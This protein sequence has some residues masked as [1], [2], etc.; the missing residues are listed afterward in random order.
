MNSGVVRSVQCRVGGD[1]GRLSI[2]DLWTPR[3]S[4]AA[5]CVAC[6]TT[7]ASVGAERHVVE[8]VG[9]HVT[10]DCSRRAVRHQTF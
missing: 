4:G 8:V 5:L 3:V 6:P 9:G 10:L 2:H 1:D 7:E